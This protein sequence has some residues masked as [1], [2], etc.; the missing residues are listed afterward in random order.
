MHFL[1]DQQGILQRYMKEATGWAAHIKHTKQEIINGATGKGNNKCAILGSGWLLDIPMEELTARFNEL[2]LIDIIHPTQIKNKYKN[3]NKIK[4]IECDVTG[5]AINEFFDSVQFHKSTGKRIE[6][7]EFKFKGFVNSE[8][9]DYIASVNILNQLDILL[10]DYIKN[11]NIYNESEL[12][13]LRK[14]IQ[15]SHIDSLPKG[16]SCLVTDYE[17]QIFGS[18][19][20][21]ES[22]RSL[23][24]VVLPENQLINQWDWQF[25]HQTYY[26]GKN[27]VFKVAAYQ[28]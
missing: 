26:P 1:A 6:P 10:I 28:L 18:G 21:P 5:G 4:C 8:G 3:N 25:D 20:Q 19:V 27:V 17:E 9:Y 22:I 11:Y 23:I 13:L 7:D 12:L 2:H 24:H 16:K 15:Q 14:K